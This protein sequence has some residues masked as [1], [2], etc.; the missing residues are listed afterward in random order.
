[1]RKKVNCLAG[2]LTGFDK[3]KATGCNASLSLCE[4]M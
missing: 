2:R 3:V 1:M 4:S